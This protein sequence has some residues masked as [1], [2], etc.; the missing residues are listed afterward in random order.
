[1]CNNVKITTKDAMILTLFEGNEA[2]SDIHVFTLEIIF[3]YV[4]IPCN[5]IPITKYCL[6]S[7]ER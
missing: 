4:L 6:Y 1:M 7:I 2:N 3:A 5:G